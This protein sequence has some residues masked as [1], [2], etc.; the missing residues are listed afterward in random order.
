LHA[1]PRDFRLAQKE[2]VAASISDFLLHLNK[3]LGL[4]MER[5]L[6]NLVQFR[7]NYAK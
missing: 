2:H 7:H 1:V 6:S 5:V 3:T 4:I